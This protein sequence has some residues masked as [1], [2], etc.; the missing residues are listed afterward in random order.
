MTVTSLQLDQPLAAVGVQNAD[1][2][3]Y[4]RHVL[5]PRAACDGGCACRG[6]ERDPLLARLAMADALAD[7]RAA[8]LATG[9]SPVVPVAPAVLAVAGGPA[10]LTRAPGTA[11]RG[12]GLPVGGLRDAA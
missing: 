7:I 6:A 12:A 1:V 5:D 8:G 11:P 3:A 10:R 4:V 2:D 9:T